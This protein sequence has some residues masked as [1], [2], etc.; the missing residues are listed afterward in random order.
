M[1]YPRMQD[2]PR[3]FLQFFASL[4]L[5]PRRRAILI[6]A[7]MALAGLTMLLWPHPRRGG[8]AEGD[9]VASLAQMVNLPAVPLSAHW[10]VAPMTATDAARPPGPN[11]WSLDATMVFSAGDAARITGAD[12]FYK[13]P[14][15]SGRLIR[16]DDT[17]FHLILYS[18]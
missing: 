6:G 5:E 16:V 17:H 10:A 14:L 11:D 15:L 7:L 1:D 9:D 4:R 12:V 18:Q 3:R 8:A 2:Q 13:A